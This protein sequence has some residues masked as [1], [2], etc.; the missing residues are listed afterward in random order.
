V[1]REQIRARVR[2]N[3]SWY[4]ITNSAGA[5][6]PAEVVIYDEIGWFG[7]T[8]A[9]FMD[10]L[11]GITAE[12]I[13]LRIN[14]PGGEIFDGIAIHNVLR[15][16]AANVTTYVDSLAASIASVIALAGDR[17]IMQPHSQMM[18]HEG[19]GLCIGDAEA[20]HEMAALLDRQSDNIAGIYAER[21]GGSPATWRDRM[22]AETWYT[23]QEAVDAGLAHEVADLPRRPSD[24][25][26]NDTTDPPE[27]RWDLSIFNHAGRDDAPRPDTS[28]PADIDPPDDTPSADPVINRSRHRWL[29]A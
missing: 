15:S 1:N 9:E 10:E 2:A 22:K 12:D 17:V 24:D 11:K 27:N 16:H 6:G 25:S 4:K 13:S 7:V 20:M 5:A 3:S 23:A 29:Y 18:I 14:S 28:S 21:A 26:G 19:S 8:A